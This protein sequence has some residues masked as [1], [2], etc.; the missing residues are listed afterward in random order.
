[1]QSNRPGT[2]TPAL[3]QRERENVLGL[4]EYS[5]ASDSSQRGEAGSLSWGRGLG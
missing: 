3:S 4:A 2:L 1:M 5:L